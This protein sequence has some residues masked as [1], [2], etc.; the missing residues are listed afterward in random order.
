MRT[1][2]P[3]SPMSRPH[4]DLGDNASGSR[5]LRP[6]PSARLPRQVKTQKP[7]ADP[8]LA[9]KGTSASTVEL[10]GRRD[11]AR[12]PGLSRGGPASRVLTRPEDL[13][14]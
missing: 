9:A 12:I 8:G 10:G 3:R 14:A 13:T 1:P 4:F 7:P 2:P 5:G 6:S 11:G